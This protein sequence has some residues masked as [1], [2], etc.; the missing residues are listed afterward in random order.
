MLVYV[1][2]VD[3]VGYDCCQASGPVSSLACKQRPA[4]LKGSCGPCK[5]CGYTATNSTWNLD[6]NKLDLPDSMLVFMGA[7]SILAAGLGMSMEVDSRTQHAQADQ[8]CFS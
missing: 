5:C 4:V 2:Y 3:G 1:A 8:V 7:K 6:T